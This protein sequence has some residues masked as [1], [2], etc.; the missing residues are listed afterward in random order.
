MLTH[1]YSMTVVFHFQ[2]SIRQ[3]PPRL[4]R[5]CLLWTTL[6]LITSTAPS[7]YSLFVHRDHIRHLIWFMSVLL[8]LPITIFTSLNAWLRGFWLEIICSPQLIHNYGYSSTK[9][10]IHL[11]CFHHN[12]SYLTIKITFIT[13]T[14]S[15]IGFIWESQSSPHLIHKSLVV[16]WR[17]DHSLHLYWFGSVGSSCFRVSFST[18]LIASCVNTVLSRSSPLKT[19]WLDQP[20]CISFITSAAVKSMRASKISTDHLPVSSY[21]VQCFTPHNIPS[22]LQTCTHVQIFHLSLI[23]TILYRSWFSQTGYLHL[24]LKFQFCEWINLLHNLLLQCW[25]RVKFLQ[26]LS[27]S[28]FYPPLCSS[29]Y[30]TSPPQFMF[31]L[32]LSSSSSVLSASPIITVLYQMTE[33]SGKSLFTFISSLVTQK[34]W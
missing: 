5:V 8:E 29:W 31:F 10:T 2:S 13:S 3:S 27:D 22:L 1:D 32:L 16:T 9:S 15:S 18:S 23:A 20:W 34:N 4:L 28:P 26:H 33:L 21:N 12:P 14:N 11:N 7:L 30:L 25:L 24:F 17:R 19:P 6:T